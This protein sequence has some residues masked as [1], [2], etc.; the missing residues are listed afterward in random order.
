MLQEHTEGAKSEQDY[1]LDIWTTIDKISNIFKEEKRHSK[2]FQYDKSKLNGLLSQVEVL[3]EKI[4]Q[5]WSYYLVHPPHNMEIQD[6]TVRVENFSFE[7]VIT[8]SKL[9]PTNCIQKLHLFAKSV[10]QLYYCIL[11]LFHISVEWNKPA[12]DL[13]LFNNPLENEASNLLLGNTEKTNY[14]IKFVDGSMLEV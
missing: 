11:E 13:C 2:N 5:L 7:K 1:R 8:D 4:H 14:K 6:L 9:C 10:A 3:S 12:S